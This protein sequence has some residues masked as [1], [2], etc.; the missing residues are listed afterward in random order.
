MGKLYLISY[1]LMTPG[2]DYT[3]LWAFLRRLGGVRVLES[4]WMIRWV[5][6]TPTTP[7][8]L[9]NA[10]LQHMDRNDRIL[11]TEVPPNFASRG[12]IAEPVAA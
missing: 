3:N 5:S 2:K 4:E 10:T 7:L 1:D 12:L 11:V 6:A 9:A 8:D